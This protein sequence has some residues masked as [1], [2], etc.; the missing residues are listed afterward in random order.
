M[1]QQLMLAMLGKEIWRFLLSLK[2]TNQGVDYLPE[3]NQWVM[4]YSGLP[5]NL[6]FCLII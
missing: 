2:S 3:W 1:V 6:S 5:S 4:Q